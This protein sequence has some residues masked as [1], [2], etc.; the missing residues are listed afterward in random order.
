MHHVTGL[1]GKATF[2]RRIAG[3]H[4][5]HRLAELGCEL[6]LLPLPEDTPE[7]AFILSR[8]NGE[9]FQYLTTTLIVALQQASS[10]GAIVYFETEYFGG[11]GG[12]GAAVFRDGKLV[13]GP[14]WAD[15]GPI[16]SALKK[17][18]VTAAPPF[19]DEFDTVGLGQFRTTEDWL[20]CAKSPLL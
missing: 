11:T 2:L 17:L 7:A 18:G 1:I 19:I 15:I 8:T 13:F 5:L 14:E 3:A 20:E 4:E 6:A 10:G 12:Q 9:E 16:N